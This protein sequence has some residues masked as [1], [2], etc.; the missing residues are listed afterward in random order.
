MF[1]T[2]GLYIT[3]D[4]YDI[5][6]IPFFNNDTQTVQYFDVPDNIPIHKVIQIIAKKLYISQYLLQILKASG[7]KIPTNH[8]IKQYSKNCYI[9]CKD[10]YLTTISFTNIGKD[11]RGYINLVQ[12]PA[13]L[14]GLDMINIVCNYNNPDTPL[15]FPAKPN[16][17]MKNLKELICWNNNKSLNMDN[18]YDNIKYITTH[19]ITIDSYDKL[20]NNKLLPSCNISPIVKTFAEWNTQKYK[21]LGQNYIPNIHNKGLI[22]YYSCINPSCSVKYKHRIINKNFVCFDLAKFKL[23]SYNTCT[24]CKNNIILTAF[25]INQCQFKLNFSCKELCTK[26]SYCKFDPYSKM[27]KITCASEMIKISSLQHASSLVITTFDLS[28]NFNSCDRC[29]MCLDMIEENSDITRCGNEHIFHTECY[30][31]ESCPICKV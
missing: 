5:I 4:T 29:P 18:D 28:D 27:G 23:S 6:H 15:K 2:D 25:T 1:T 24:E 22:L 11:V 3:C 10:E 14:N 12:H 13:L 19:D 21:F 30:S 8:I 16:F 7:E 17:T 31:F 26:N 9:R 20:L